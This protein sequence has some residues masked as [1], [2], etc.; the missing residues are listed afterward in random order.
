MNFFGGVIHLLG[1]VLNIRSARHEVL[2]ANIANADTPG[3]RAVDLVFEEELKKAARPDGEKGMTQTHPKHF[4]NRQSANPIPGRVEPTG[5]TFRM[6]GNSVDVERQMV[7]L[8]ENSLMYE[9]AVQMLTKK[10]RGLKDVIRE[11]R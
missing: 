5:P 6:D 8:A 7:K 2:A 1:E 9:A 11:G 10:F 4:S 3:Y